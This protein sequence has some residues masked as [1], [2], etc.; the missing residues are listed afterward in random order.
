MNQNNNNSAAVIIDPLPAHRID[1]GALARWLQREVPD[2]GN[3]LTVRQFQGGMSN[4]TYLLTTSDGT[5]YVL[6]KKPPGDLLPKAHAIDREFRVMGALQNTDVPVPEMVAYCDDPGV[7][8]AEF[9]VMKHVEGR[10]IP[11]DDMGSVTAEERTPLSRSLISTLGSLH[12][13]DWRQ[14][15]LE[16]FGRPEGYLGRQTS[17]WSSQYEA[18]KSSLPADFDYSEMDWLRDWLMDHSQV[19]DESAIVHGDYRIGNAI[20]HPE[21]PVVIS[22]LDWELSTIGHPLADL[23]YLC[24]HY[25]LPG[26]LG[27]TAD[28][29]QPGLPTE[30]EALAWYCEQTGRKGIPDWPVFLAFAFFRGAAIAQGVAARAARGN[31]S[32]ASMD[33][34]VAGNRARQLAKAGAN[35]ARSLAGA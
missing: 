7:I 5:R 35:I 1:S 29:P 11:A 18:A 4:P 33:P 10:I 22:V 15:G 2:A 31:V 32:T 16:S 17:R 24:L 23:A 25:H 20:V 19:P 30:Q 28:R 13:V 12:R 8:G 34:A 26:E 6:R 27:G 3:G 14:A 9:Y 21:K